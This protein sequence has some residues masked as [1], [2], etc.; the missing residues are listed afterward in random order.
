MGA[1]QLLRYYERII[2]GLE[3]AL[4]MLAQRGFEPSG[5]W[6]QENQERLNNN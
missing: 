4:E 1:G 2:E 5:S 3:Q 6:L